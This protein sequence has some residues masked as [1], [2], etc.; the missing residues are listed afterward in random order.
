MYHGQIK[1]LIG[2]LLSSDMLLA[3][4]KWRYCSTAIIYI[5]RYIVIVIYIYI[6]PML[7]VLAKKF[8]DLNIIHNW[9]NSVPHWFSVWIYV[10]MWWIYRN[11]VKSDTESVITTS[12]LLWYNR[13]ICG[14]VFSKLHTD[15]I[16]RL[17][18]V[19]T[20]LLSIFLFFFRNHILLLPF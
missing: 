20:F 16:H 4:Q 10:N 6:Y 17:V 15:C 9:K 11:N 1:T 3:E 18:I 2:R 13:C 19:P 14:H 5:E 12:H 8:L 7:H